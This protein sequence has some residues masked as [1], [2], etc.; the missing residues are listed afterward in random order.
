M[1]A[2]R[3]SATFNR[4]RPT[5]AQGQAESARQSAAT[6][7]AAFEQLRSLGFT[8]ALCRP[9]RWAG[10]GRRRPGRARMGENPG[11]KINSPWTASIVKLPDR[12]FRPRGYRKDGSHPGRG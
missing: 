4:S 11:P 7:M 6:M 12:G 2:S 9:H 1:S 5:S 10:R 3:R 8:S